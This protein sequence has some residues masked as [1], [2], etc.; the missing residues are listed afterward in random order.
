MIVAMVQG[1]LKKRHCIELYSDGRYIAC[2]WGT[3]TVRYH[4]KGP[5]SKYFLNIN[6]G[7]AFFHVDAIQR[8]NPDHPC[9][10]GGDS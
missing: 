8:H 1:S 6:G 5:Q 3:A 9:G 4:A 2:A 7:E 10:K